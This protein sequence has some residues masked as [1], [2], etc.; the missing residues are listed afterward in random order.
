MKRFKISTKKESLKLIVS[1]LIDSK[2]NFEFKSAQIGTS[3]LIVYSKESKE[4]LVNTIKEL[5]SSD[6]I[7]QEL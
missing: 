7:I 2:L 4:E 3:S 1:F 6:F 5:I